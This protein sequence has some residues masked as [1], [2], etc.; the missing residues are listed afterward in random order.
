MFGCFVLRVRGLHFADLGA[1]ATY[2]CGL[3][4]VVCTLLFV[5]HGF[6]CGFWWG[7]VCL[8]YLFYVMLIIGLGMVGMDAVFLC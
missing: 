4:L 3:R 5:V 6:V 8:L 2:T 7:L 1:Y